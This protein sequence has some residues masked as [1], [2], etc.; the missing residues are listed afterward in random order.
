MSGGI[1]DAVSVRTAGG[2]TTTVFFEVFPP[3]G[4]ALPDDGSI[5]D[6]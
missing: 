1:V 3:L 5:V 6:T 2:R 4:D